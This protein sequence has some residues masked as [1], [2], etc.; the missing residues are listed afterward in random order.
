MGGPSFH[1]W[2]G[3]M[4]FF[5]IERG[6]NTQQIEWDC[7]WATPDLWASSN[8]PCDEDGENCKLD[9]ETRW[10][11]REA[12]IMASGEVNE[13]IKKPRHHGAGGGGK[14]SGDAGGKRRGGGH[15]RAMGPA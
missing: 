12:E 7:A 3:E 14:R 9:Q 8:Y 13:K 6:K 10:W 2:Q 5:R 11:A 4:G 1:F 15:Q